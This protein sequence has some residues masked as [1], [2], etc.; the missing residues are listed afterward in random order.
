[1]GLVLCTF[2]LTSTFFPRLVV[3]VAAA[4]VDADA[5]DFN[6]RLFIYWISSE[7]NSQL[8]ATISSRPSNLQDRKKSLT[9]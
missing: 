6:F 8:T 2:L 4:D 1:M 3:A 7:H 9:D 5:V